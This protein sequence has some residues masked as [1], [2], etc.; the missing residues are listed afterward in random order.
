MQTEYVEVIM[1]G[2]EGVD[3]KTVASIRGILR[4]AGIVD[5]VYLPPPARPSEQLILKAQP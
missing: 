1:A 5:L 4:R 2:T 3:A